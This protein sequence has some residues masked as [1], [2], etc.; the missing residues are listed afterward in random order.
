MYSES[1]V[2][3]L[4]HVSDSKQ[5]CTFINPVAKSQTQMCVENIPKCNHAKMQTP[6]ARAAPVKSQ[7]T[8]VQPK[9]CRL[10]RDEIKSAG[11]LIC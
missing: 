7:K 10:T 8:L 5:S 11:A 2:N 9:N 3:C 4:R 6:L 1:G